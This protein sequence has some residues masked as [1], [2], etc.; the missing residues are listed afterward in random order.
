MKSM[1]L[2]FLNVTES[3]AIAA[4][5]WIGSGDKIAADNAATNV[6]R[7]TFNLLPI[8]GTVVIGEGEI[9]DAPMLF[10]GEKLGKGNSPELDI[11]V[12]PIEGTTPTVNGQRNA[13]TVIAAA[14]KGS[15]LHAPDMYMEKIAV[16]PKAKGKIDIELPLQDNMKKVAEANG[17]QVNELN[18]YVQD[19]PR[20]EEYIRTI[21][22]AGAKVH[23]FRDGDVIYSTATCIKN[24][25]VDMFIGI[26]GAPEGVLSAVAMK[27][28]GGEMQAR[29]I[30]QSEDEVKRC[31]RMGMKEPKC[32]LYHHQLVNSDDCAFIATGI[33]DN[34]LLNGIKT[35]SGQHMTQSILISGKEKRLRYI[36]SVH[37]M[38][39]ARAATIES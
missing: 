15:L 9:D 13:I 11:A 3:A 18:I 29:L 26:G 22:E 20:H 32:A 17:K 38:Q 24:M 2:D 19:R 6:M 7:D 12:D 36:E 37:V 21:R 33:T 39:E 34:L 28:L 8:S 25:N 4:S 14:P 35:D 16:G 27:S 30:P 31:L 1:L 23:L 5:P 10:I